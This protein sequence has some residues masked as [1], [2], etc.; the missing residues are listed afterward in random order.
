MAA[1]TI[2]QVRARVAEA[3][4][5]LSGWTESRYHPESFGSDTSSLLHL[6]FAVG[7]PTTDLQDA[8]RRQV[9][10]AGSLVV[11][12]VTVDI[13]HKIRGDAQVTDTDAALGVEH[14][15]LKTVLAI[16]RADLHI[17][18]APNVASRK[19]VGDGTCLVCT[20]RFRAIHTLALQ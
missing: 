13:A 14:T 19:L 15:G 20:L 4:E 10:A 18:M 2:P 9:L 11:T 6:S 1:L 7:T 5:A 16:P 3:L 12:T 17:V 8:D